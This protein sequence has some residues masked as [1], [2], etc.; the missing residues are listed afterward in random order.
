VDCPV[1]PEERQ[2]LLGTMPWAVFTAIA[3]VAVDST[4]DIAA[5]EQLL[6]QLA[7]FDALRD[8]LDRHFLRRGSILRAYRI[9][10]NA[11][12]VLTALRFG[13]VERLR[14][15]YLADA[16]QRDRFLAFVRASGGDP[17]VARDLQAFIEHHLTPRSDAQTMIKDIERSC[18]RLFHNLE[19][20]NAD[21]QALQQLEDG[22]REGVFSLAELD[23]LRALLGLYGLDLE[24]R[25]PPS[26]ISVAY[27]EQRQ[28]VWSEVCAWDR[29]PTRA[30]VAERAVA[31]YGHILDELLGAR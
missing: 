28:Q 16:A 20:F 5:V 10:A 1:T 24:K 14:R 7:G 17:G 6:R 25:L 29:K 12:Q 23:E 18:A 30:Q 4:L 2:E 31:R 11:R 22:T 15:Q 27:V 21:A 19:E 3:T 26:R 9:V 13:E 8:V